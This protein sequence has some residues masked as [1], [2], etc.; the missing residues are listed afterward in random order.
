MPDND[1]VVDAMDLA[2]IGDV[3]DGNDGDGDWSKEPPDVDISEVNNLTGVNLTPGDVRMMNAKIDEVIV[4]SVGVDG[5]CTYEAIL[6]G[7]YVQHTGAIGGLPLDVEQWWR[8]ASPTLIRIMAEFKEQL[9]YILLRDI[10]NVLDDLNYVMLPLGYVVNLYRRKAVRYL[11]DTRY[12]QKNTK[13]Y[14]LALAHALY[15]YPLDEAVVS[16]EKPLKYVNL[17]FTGEDNVQILDMAVITDISVLSRQTVKDKRKRLRKL[18]SCEH[19]FVSFARKI[20]WQKHT[21][22]CRGANAQDFR[23]EDCHLLTFEDHLKNCRDTHPVTVYYDLETAA[24]AD[25]RMMTVISYAYMFVFDPNLNYATIVVYRSLNMSLEEL[26][27][28]NIPIQLHIP[29]ADV[30]KLEK[31]AHDVMRRKD[32]A[33]AQMLTMEISILQHAVVKAM[34]AQAEAHGI[35][36]PHRILLAKENYQVRNCYVCDFGLNDETTIPFRDSVQFCLRKVYMRWY[37]M[38]REAAAPT[39]LEISEEE[40][41]NVWRNAMETVSTSTVQLYP[42]EEVEE[43]KLKQQL[44]SLFLSMCYLC[45][46]EHAPQCMLTFT[47][48]EEEELLNILNDEVVVHHNHYTGTVYGPVHKR[49]NSRCQLVCN[50]KTNVYAHNTT[51]FDHNFMIKGINMGLLARSGEKLPTFD[52]LGETSERLRVMTVGDCTYKDSCK[53]FDSSLTDLCKSKV[54]EECECSESIL[55]QYLQQHSHFAAVYA[56]ADPADLKRV[57]GVLGSGKGYYPYDYVSSAA[58]LKENTFPPLKAFANCLSNEPTDPVRYAKAKDIWDTL[59][60]RNMDD[61]TCL[62]NLMD[63]IDLGVIC[64]ERMG[65]LKD[66]LKLD[67]R[68]YTSIS[69][70]GAACAK[71]TCHSITQSISSEDVLD[72]VE[73]AT[74]GGFSCVSLRRAVSSRFYEP[75][76]VPAPSGVAGERVRVMSTIEALDENNQYGHKMMQKLCSGGFRRR[77]APEAVL[78]GECQSILRKYR[79]EDDRGYFFQVDLVLPKGNHTGAEEMYPSVFER[80]ECNLGSLSP[81]QLLHLR[82]PSKLKKR[83]FNKVYFS[84]KNMGTMQRKKRIWVMV[85]LLQLQVKQGWAITRVHTY[86]SFPQSYTMKSYIEANQKR[87]MQSTDAVT[88]KLMKDAN[89][90]AFGANTQ[91]IR[92]R[93]KVVPIIDKSVMGLLRVLQR[94]RNAQT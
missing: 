86:Y 38:T 64:E 77:T 20:T 82:R 87:R 40:V 91:R 70:Y 10:A 19:C 94:S 22:W 2:D 57:L 79:L 48:S 74:H 54:P 47:W 33:L 52:L 23:F 1:E 73:A 12:T 36:A 61:F 53:V 37:C 62:Y 58:V 46:E 68:N 88:I 31:C 27:M 49:C 24:D 30:Q 85:E 51:N 44:Q 41:V 67:V 26:L 13:Q 15:R 50:F 21:R 78:M 59:Q 84:T 60:C 4:K 7:L 92:N 80:E 25:T 89:N 34:A 66:Y 14:V 28:T 43:K 8:V 56:S 69:V 83:K 16:K 5:Y 71:Y 75:M 11:L 42:P 6:N 72:V 17:I 93:K 29:S 9:R 90:K 18:Y 32:H 39:T 63:T 3:A 45:V 65:R 55:I 35:L 81:Y 76:F